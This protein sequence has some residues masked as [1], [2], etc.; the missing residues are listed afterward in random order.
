MRDYLSNGTP[1]N[2][3]NG[4]T[5]PVYIPNSTNGCDS[6]SP[7]TSSCLNLTQ[8]MG[9]VTGGVP[10]N[11]TPNQNWTTTS[12]TTFNFYVVNGKTGASALTLPFVGGNA[13][14]IEIVRRPPQGESTSSP[15]GQSRLFNKAQLRILLADTE[16]Q[17]VQGT[18]AAAG[19]PDNVQLDHET[20]SYYAGGIAVTGVAGNS[21]FGY[22]NTD[23]SIVS[24]A[25]AGWCEPNDQAPPYAVSTHGANKKQ[26][27]LLESGLVDAT[28]KPQ[29][30]WLRVEYMDAGGN[31]HG[32]TRQW[33]TL[34]F[35]R[36]L[37]PPTS[38]GANSV[39]PNAILILQ[40]QADR[41]GD[42]TLTKPGTKLSSAYKD[43]ANKT[44]D[45]TGQREAGPNGGTPA[46]IA[47]TNTRY[48]WYPI[49]F[50]DPREG[51]SRDS[52]TGKSGTCAPN[53]HL[54]RRGAR[55]R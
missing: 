5:G 14:P 33:L 36:G 35:A 50:Y 22:A 16:S 49:N 20:G 7:P 55:C 29:A 15:V 45:T 41:D 23:C 32:V 54:E 6:G 8:T 18:S 42:G 24:G 47:G 37:T 10:P 48:I 44:Y 53:G 40:Q 38:P 27:P 46:V 13:G 21:Y 4:Y 52:Q 1:A 39:H 26:W 34:G 31:W 43:A 2:S 12:Q 17:L 30:A 28:G 51:E 9:S 19:D 3:A 25:S 11:G